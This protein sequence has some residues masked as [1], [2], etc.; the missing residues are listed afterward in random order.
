MSRPHG[1]SFCNYG[2]ITL[3]TS[4]RDYP[5]SSEIRGCHINPNEVVAER[6]YQGFRMESSVI[7]EGPLA[8][9]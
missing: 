7:Y 6:G 3:Y 5:A 9:E 8:Y 2:Y 1:H 4:W